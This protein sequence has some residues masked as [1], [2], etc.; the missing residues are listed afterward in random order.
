MEG[1]RYF[2]RIS[3]LT[4]LDRF[5]KNTQISNS[6]N[7]CA[8]GAELFYEHG[9]T[10][11]TKLTAVFRNFAKAPKDRHTE[12]ARSS[13]HNVTFLQATALFSYA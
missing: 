5:S 12:T 2:L 9:R 6:M 11:M 8:V 1:R 7:I 4:L 10:D 13:F 3:K